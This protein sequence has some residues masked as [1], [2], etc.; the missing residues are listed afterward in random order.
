MD[1]QIPLPSQVFPTIFTTHPPIR[2]RAVLTDL[3]SFILTPNL[4][5]PSTYLTTPGHGIVHTPLWIT[6]NSEN[7]PPLLNV[8]HILFLLF[9]QHCELDDSHRS[10]L[11]L[12][13]LLP[14]SL[15]KTYL[16]D[17]AMV[18]PRHPLNHRLRDG[19]TRHS[20]HFEGSPMNWMLRLSS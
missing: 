17:G 15:T 9:Q 6:I 10:W 13:H 5:R 20:T 12:L 19:G 7:A 16:Q 3:K 1:D 14:W 4:I 11:A 8:Q 18:P 2:P